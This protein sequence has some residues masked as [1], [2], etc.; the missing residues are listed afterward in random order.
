MAE[1]DFELRTRIT[2]LERQVGKLKT[3]N[4]LLYAGNLGLTACV[5]ASV[6]R[7]DSELSEDALRRLVGDDTWVDPNE[8][9]FL[10]R[11]LDRIELISRTHLALR[12]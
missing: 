11:A 5:L 9:D 8:A 12:E 2:E 6:T 7:I 4:E 1:D 3:E 10:K